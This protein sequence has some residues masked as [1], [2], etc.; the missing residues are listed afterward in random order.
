MV[1]ADSG[2][3]LAPNYSET[4]VVRPRRNAGAPKRL[5]DWIYNV[6]LGDKVVFV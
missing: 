5:G 4:A 1:P 6:S 2:E 3:D